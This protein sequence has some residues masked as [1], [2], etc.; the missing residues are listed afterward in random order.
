MRSTGPRTLPFRSLPL[1]CA[2]ALT[3][4]WPAHHGGVRVGLRKVALIAAMA[5]G[6][7]LAAVGAVQLTGS[8]GGAVIPMG[9]AN[10]GGIGVPPSPTQQTTEPVESSPTSLPETTLP[11]TSPASCSNSVYGF[12]ITIPIG[13]AD[14]ATSPEQRCRAIDDQPPEVGSDGAPIVP[15]SM[16]AEDRFYQ[17]LSTAFLNDQDIFILDSKKVQAGKNRATRIE[18]YPKGHSDQIWYM[19]VV[20]DKGKSFEIW[21]YAPYSHDFEAVI[22]AVDA[23]ESSITFTQ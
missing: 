15:I 21:G 23:I 8:A 11:S 3:E 19:Y 17:E 6:L 10:P 2:L 5:G 14:Y 16:R 9:L 12:T 20:D 7:A 1:L 4:H 13:W 22:T 18:Y